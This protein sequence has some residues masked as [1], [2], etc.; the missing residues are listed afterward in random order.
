M[1]LYAG[2]KGIFQGSKKEIL[3][4]SKCE[5]NCSNRID[6]MK[7]FFTYTLRIHILKRKRNLLNAKT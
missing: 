4:P 7:Y 1:E 6:C 2:Q 3:G 5:I